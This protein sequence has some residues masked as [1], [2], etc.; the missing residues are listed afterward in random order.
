MDELH[1]YVWNSGVGDSA[2]TEH[3][4]DQNS[5]GPDVALVVDHP[6]HQDLGSHPPHRQTRADAGEVLH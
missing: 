5:E 1:I 3:L 4:P 6:G 2:K